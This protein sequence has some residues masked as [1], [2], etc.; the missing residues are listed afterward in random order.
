[1][2]NL[3]LDTKLPDQFVVKDYKLTGA[4]LLHSVAVHDY[5][6]LKRRADEIDEAIINATC[7]ADDGDGDP[8]EEVR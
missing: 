1:M 5:A 2:S 7:S 8:R 6:D 4:I 3:S